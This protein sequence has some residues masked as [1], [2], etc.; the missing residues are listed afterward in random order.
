MAETF[1]F[2]VAGAG[3]NALIAAAYLTKAGFECGV[4]DSRPILGGDTATEELTLPGFLHDTCSTAHNLIQAS[5]TL[6]DDE[7]RL[8][9]FGLEY[10][11]P[12]PVVHI[13]FP[14]PRDRRTHRSTATSCGRP[15]RETPGPRGRGPRAVPAPAD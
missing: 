14:D 4:L 10:I 15:M 13:P 6:R 12:D 7:L 9:D 1:D 8:G 3:H 2:V 11:E 5:P